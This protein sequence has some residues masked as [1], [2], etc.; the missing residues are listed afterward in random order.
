MANRFQKLIYFL[1]AESPILVMVAI[2]WLIDRKIDMDK[3]YQYKLE[4]SDTTN[5]CIRFPDPHL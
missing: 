1:S 4:G 3:T 5:Y 2:V